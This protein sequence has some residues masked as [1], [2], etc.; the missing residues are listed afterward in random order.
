MKS[1]R[2]F[3]WISSHMLLFFLFR[4]HP[5][6]VGV[7]WEDSAF[8][9]LSDSTDGPDYFFSKLYLNLW[10]VLYFE[11]TLRHK[12]RVSFDLSRSGPSS[13]PLAGD[14]A[15]RKNKD[16]WDIRAERERDAGRLKVW[17]TWRKEVSR[18][19]EE[20]RTTDERSAER[21]E[22]RMEED[23]P[24]CHSEVKLKQF[25]LLFCIIF[26]NLK[27]CCIKERTQRG[28]RF[29][30]QEEKLAPLYNSIKVRRSKTLNAEATC[31]SLMLCLVVLMQ[32]SLSS[33]LVEWT[34]A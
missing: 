29:L 27:S 31:F 9:L 30:I 24:G 12:E 21:K 22:R 4:F 10:S 26:C 13:S 8:M 20:G 33:V 16:W 7:F 17:K 2:C 3:N 25:L 15:E 14:A 19:Q 6:T 28:V 5:V 1:E 32:E 23:A 34:G 11:H 18:Q